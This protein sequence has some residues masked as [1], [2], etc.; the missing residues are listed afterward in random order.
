MTNEELAQEI[1]SGNDKAKEQLYTQVY[2]LIYRYAMNF[3]AAYADRCMSCGIELDDMLTEGYFAMIDAVKAYC[4]SDSGYKFNTF[5]T[6]P[7]KNSFYGLIGYDSKKR[8]NDPL[9]SCE[10]LDKPLPDVEDTTLAD[11]VEDKSVT[12][13]EDILRD[14]TLSGVFKAAKAALTDIPHAYDIL[15]L[16]YVRGL[17][18]VKIAAKTGIPEQEVARLKQ[19][20]LRELRRPKNKLVPTYREEIL[21][22]SWRLSGLE[23]FRNTGESSVEWAVQRLTESERNR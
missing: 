22:T 3:Q 19:Q 21:G 16:E 10:S 1:Y 7:L 14:I 5:M 11:T 20:A 12:F 6:Y 9:N 17:T 23:R 8:L 18:R 4:E 15:Y 2:R 13:A